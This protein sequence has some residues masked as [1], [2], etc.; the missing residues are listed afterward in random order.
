MKKILS[1]VAV[2][3]M[4]LGL[5]GCGNSNNNTDT[6]P[7]SV[8]EQIQEKGYITLA[9]SPDFAPNEFYVL[10]DGQQTIVGTDIFLAEAVAEEIGVELKISA[11]EFN[12]VISEVQSGLAD[13]GLSGFAWTETRAAT[14]KFSESYAQTAD[15]EWQGLM[16]RKEDASKYQSLD[17]IKAANLTIGAQLG[18]IQYEMASH[19][20]DTSN[21]VS[22][23]DNTILALEL[24]TGGIDAYVITSTQGAAA[25]NA[26]DGIVLLPGDSFNLDPENKYDQ[27]CAVFAKDADNES[28]IEI[29]N[30]VITEAKEVGADG[31]C[32]LDVW[33]DEA[34]AL[35]PFDLTA[36]IYGY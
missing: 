5:T 6:T 21:I 13:F 11:V 25:M 19:L 29:V 4:V 2:L 18:S 22:I 26:N 36:E 15:D 31:R 7:K 14:V 12:N 35:L 34:E 8:L 28:L 16:V 9:T 17:D 27:M 24:A 32:Q 23:G 30:K 20:T 33:N 10:Q 1:M 3:A